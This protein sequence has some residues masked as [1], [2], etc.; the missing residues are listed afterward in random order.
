[1]EEDDACF[2]RI[3][4]NSRGA[5]RVHGGVCEDLLCEASP[6][7]TGT[8]TGCT[9]QLYV[10]ELAIRPVPM[11]PSATEGGH[12]AHKTQRANP[13]SH[14]DVTFRSTGCGNGPGC[15]S[16]DYW[17]MARTEHIVNS[18]FGLQYILR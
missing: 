5:L 12:C 9:E 17:D 14:T 6:D 1:M 10:P 18:A 16:G 3:P 13:R 2:Q 15:H 4:V 8:S 7:C 11:L